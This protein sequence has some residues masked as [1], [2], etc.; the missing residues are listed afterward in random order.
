MLA[1][2]L[3]FLLRPS[4]PLWKFCLAAFPLALIPSMAL[5]ASVYLLLAAVGVDLNGI[6]R[7]SPSAT[8]TGLFGA[9]VVAPIVETCVLSLLLIALLKMGVRPLFGAVVSAVLW[10]AL[11]ATLAPLW[12]FGTV[13]SFFV[14]SC[15][16]IGWRERSFNQAFVAA[17]VPHAL[18]NLSVMATL[19]LDKAA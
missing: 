1:T 10:G 3:S 19:T 17:A 8:A 18:I 16:F 12:F 9:V 14:F 15:A 7:P 13:W 5:F 6:Q 2:L 11:H 4:L